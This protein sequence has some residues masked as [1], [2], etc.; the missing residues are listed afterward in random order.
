MLPVLIQMAVLIAGGAVWRY[1]KPSG[2]DPDVVRR[3]LTS[4]VY[5][6][7]LPALIL[8]VMWRAPVGVDSL[9]IAFV[10]ASTVLFGL[11]V[12]GLLL[13]LFPVPRPLAGAVLLAAGFPNATY[14]GLPVLEASFGPAA[15][16]IAIQYDL[17]ACTLLLM[18]VGVYLAKRL[19]SGYSAGSVRLMLID[20]FKIP[21]LWAMLLALILNFTGLEPPSLID[22]I[23]GLLGACVIPLMLLSLGMSLRWQTI[24][25]RMR[26]WLSII[27]FIQLLL[28]PAFAWYLG[29]MAGMRGELFWAT[30]IEAAMPCMVLGVVI[31]DR[32]HLHTPLYATAVTVTTIVSLV[33][34]P[35]WLAFA[36][37]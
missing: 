8:Q 23:L 5:Y 34:L 24:D 28:C 21:P 33:S 18:T 11:T 3:S 7:L 32:Y 29:S 35:L 26:I 15:R 19:G 37:V 36:G 10:A 30:V 14:L 20:L 17:L 9:R 2:L 16:S 4:L 25:M 22:N 6:L 13:K 12:A 31:C 1:L 27:A